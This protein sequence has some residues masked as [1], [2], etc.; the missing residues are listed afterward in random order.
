M[1]SDEGTGHRP[2]DC[3]LSLKQSGDDAYRIADYGA[4]VVAYTR[5]IACLPCEQ[6]PYLRAT[7]HSNRCLALLKGGQDAYHALR[8][9]QQACGLRPRWGKANLRLAQVRGAHSVTGRQFSEP[10]CHS[11]Q[12]GPSQHLCYSFQLQH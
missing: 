5:A 6:E 9:A 7:L 12:D 1:G 8:D 11:N 3:L 2:S 10:A 4:A